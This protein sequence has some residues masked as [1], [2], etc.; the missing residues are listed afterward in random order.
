M[1]QEV[2]AFLQKPNYE[3]YL[4]LELRGK[5]AVLLKLLILTTIFSLALGFLGFAVANVLAIPMENHA[6]AEFIKESSALQII[7]L[8]TVVAPLIEELIFRGPLYFFRNFRYFPWIF[9]AS[10]IIFGAVHLS[11]FEMNDQLIWLSPLLIL[12]QVSAGVFLGFIRIKLGL[13]WSILLHA[14]FN[15]LLLSPFI[16]IKIIKGFL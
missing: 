6:I 14:A 16:F 5:L 8:V 13:L 15:T 9:Y 12:P 10:A 1:R 11:N 3:P 4:Q 2:L 7:F